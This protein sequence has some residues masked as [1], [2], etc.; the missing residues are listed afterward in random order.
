VCAKIIAKSTAGGRDTDRP[1]LRREPMHCDLRPTEGPIPDG[2]EL[3]VVYITGG[4]RTG[5][6]VLDTILGNHPDVVS[7]GEACHVPQKAWLNDGFCACGERGGDCPFWSEVRRRWS[8]LTGVDAVDDYA[9]MI[10]ELEARQIWLPKLAAEARRPESPYREYVRLTG[11]LMTAIGQASGKRILVDSSKRASRAFALSLAAEVD[12]YVVHLVRDCRGVVYSGKKRFKK[13]EKHG[14]SKDDPGRKVSRSAM[15]W[16]VANLQA[17][18]IRRQL[19]AN[20]S[21]RVRYE[22]YATRPER[23]LER[24]GRLIGLDLG[25]V[26]RAVAE[27]APMRIGHTIAGNRLRMGGPVQLRADTQWM[28]E[29]TAWDRWKCWALSGPLLWHYGYGARPRVQPEATLRRA[30]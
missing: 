21:I 19:P 29:L 17:S 6:T 12:L 26:A 18:W 24:I 16:N 1:A 14:V 5:S 28:T 27:G 7:V 13:D 22:D 3:R 11:A 15:I 2:A 10:R 25:G 23:E 20:R 4:G 8:L 30:A 9:R